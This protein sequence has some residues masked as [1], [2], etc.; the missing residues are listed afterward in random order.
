VR[1]YHIMHSFSMLVH[2]LYTIYPLLGLDNAIETQRVCYSTHVS[3]TSPAPYIYRAIPNK[4]QMFFME[5]DISFERSPYDRH[6]ALV[7]TGGRVWVKA[8]F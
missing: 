1:L 8:L 3:H 6:R 7:H 5:K 4:E 2:L